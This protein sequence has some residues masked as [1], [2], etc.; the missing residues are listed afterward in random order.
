MGSQTLQK[1]NGKSKVVYTK[2][3]TYLSDK[4]KKTLEKLAKAEG[5]SKYEIINDAIA[6][7]ALSEK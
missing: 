7:Y 4:S 6:F 3:S 5:K 2:T 1:K